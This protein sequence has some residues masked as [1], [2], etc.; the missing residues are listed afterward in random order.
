MTEEERSY[1]KADVDCSG[2]EPENCHRNKRLITRRELGVIQEGRAHLTN[3]A[4]LSGD[5][6][7]G[8]V[9]RN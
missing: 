1:R 3:Q 6:H 5:E 7:K 8:P 9:K 2:E 4:S